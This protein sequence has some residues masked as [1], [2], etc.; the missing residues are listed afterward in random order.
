MIER[1]G[2]GGRWETESQREKG[3]KE[4]KLSLL[5]TNLD[6]ELFSLINY[7]F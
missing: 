3:R 2:D 5:K 4:T 7:H 6:I 1:K